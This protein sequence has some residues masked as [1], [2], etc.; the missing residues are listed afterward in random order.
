MAREGLAG[1]RRRGDCRALRRRQELT[2][3]WVQPTAAPARQPSLDPMARR[4][5]SRKPSY[6]WTNAGPFP[7]KKP[8]VRT[9]RVHQNLI[10]H[11]GSYPQEQIAFQ[12]NEIPAPWKP[13][14]SPA[15]DCTYSRIATKN[16]SENATVS[17]KR[18]DART[19][20]SEG[21]K[22]RPGRINKLLNQTMCGRATFRH[23]IFSL[24]G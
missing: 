17:G 21:R 4:Q 15:I 9:A 10:G 24:L 20:L 22:H 16:T 8:T 7:D 12:G 19:F 13:Y 23:R 2:V 5:S 3:L 6:A 18:H 1:P 11:H 14:P